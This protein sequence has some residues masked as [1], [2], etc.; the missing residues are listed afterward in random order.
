MHADGAPEVLRQT[1]DA[2]RAL[3]MAQIEELMRWS[4][5]R[6]GGPAGVEPE[7]LAHSVMALAEHGARLVLTDPVRYSPARL[8]EHVARMVGALERGVTKTAESPGAGA[9]PPRERHR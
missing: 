6:R 7:L 4:L 3:V 8:T 1:V 2:D 5:E 9:A